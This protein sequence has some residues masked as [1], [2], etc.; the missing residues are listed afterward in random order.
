MEKIERDVKLNKKKQRKIKKKLQRWWF[1]SQYL[2][3]NEQILF[4]SHI[5]QMSVA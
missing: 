3:I 5:T 1:V 4:L 2:N